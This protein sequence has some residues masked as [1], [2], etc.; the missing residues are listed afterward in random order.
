MQRLRRHSTGS[1]AALVVADAPEGLSRR[2]RMELEACGNEGSGKLGSGERSGWAAADGVAGAGGQVPAAFGAGHH[3]S[4]DGASPSGA[5]ASPAT[6]AAAVAAA[7]RSP[8]S[9]R[10]L[11]SVRHSH[12]SAV[13]AAE[14]RRGSGGTSREPLG[15]FALL[16]STETGPYAAAAAAAGASTGAN[17]SGSHSRGSPSGRRALLSGGAVSPAF[18]LPSGLGRASFN[19]FASSRPSPTGSVDAGVS[20]SAAP[21]AGPAAASALAAPRLLSDPVSLLERLAYRIDTLRSHAER[22][23]GRDAFARVYGY[24][25]ASEQAEQAGEAGGLEDEEP[26]NGV[27]DQEGGGSS[28]DDHEDAPGGAAAHSH[29]VA[30]G[31]RSGGA[32]ADATAAATQLPSAASGEGVDVSNASSSALHLPSGLVRGSGALDS[33]LPA[34]PPGFPGSVGLQRMMSAPLAGSDPLVGAARLGATMSAAGHGHASM[35]LSDQLALASTTTRGASP[36]ATA[37]ASAA[38]SRSARQSRGGGSK[39]DVSP[40]L[41]GAAGASAASAFAIPLTL[42]SSAAG[43]AVLHYRNTSISLSPHLG[44]QMGGRGGDA[45]RLLAAATTVAAAAAAPAAP[46]VDLLPLNASHAVTG[47][48]SGCGAGSH[49]DRGVAARPA[50]GAFPGGAQPITELVTSRDHA[51]SP[52]AL[53]LPALLREVGAEALGRVQL[54]MGLEDKLAATHEAL[55]EAVAASAAQSAGSAAR[56]AR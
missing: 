10:W 30:D 31:Q 26:S 23:M 40:A 29:T 32:T 45:S 44:G 12:N 34:V 47:L 37:E 14:R 4:S 19:G 25:R 24:L 38:A 5:A 8:A 27:H 46:A 42:S 50:A 11:R 13:A 35:T 53:P 1:A 3:S 33:S 6:A 9:A 17:V 16:P 56:G 52:P 39:L 54:I 49:S 20:R 43:S 28:L 36:V 55:L 48:L 2:S 18:N 15:P 51:P 7:C 41:G 22:R 21:A